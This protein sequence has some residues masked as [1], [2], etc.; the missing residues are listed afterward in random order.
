MTRVS[1]LAGNNKYELAHNGYFSFFVDSF[2][3][4]PMMKTKPETKKTPPRT[5]V[6]PYV[7]GVSQKFRHIGN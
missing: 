2:F 1:Q 3:K 6:I 4:G 7:M 5:A